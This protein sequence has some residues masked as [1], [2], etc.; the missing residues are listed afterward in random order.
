MLRIEILN[1]CMPK[2][3]SLSLMWNEDVRM[4]ALVG[5]ENVKADIVER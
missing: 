5:G 1:N 4:H 2:N 3:Y